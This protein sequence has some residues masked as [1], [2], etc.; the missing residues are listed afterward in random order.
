MAIFNIVLPDS[1]DERNKLMGLV[2]ALEEN[3][4]MEIRDALWI[5]TN[6]AFVSPILQLLQTRVEVVAPDQGPWKVEGIDPITYTSY[7]ED[8]PTVACLNCGKEFVQKR[9]DNWTCSKACYQIYQRKSGAKGGKTTQARKPKEST[10]HFDVNKEFPVI[11]PDGDRVSRKDLKLA[12]E[13]HELD[14]GDRVMIDS[15][16]HV[17]VS[18][19]GNVLDVHPLVGLA[20]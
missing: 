16:E 19:L 1:E 4:H 17:V 2:T 7:V 18:G 8:K 10:T 11:L 6:N 3:F 20:A 15:K 9:K 5:Q 12:L 13:N 14:A